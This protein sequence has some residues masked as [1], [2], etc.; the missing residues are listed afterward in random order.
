MSKL[1]Y[2]ACFTILLLTSGYSRAQDVFSSSELQDAIE[3]AVGCELSARVRMAL[4]VL[5][6]YQ[7]GVSGCES[8][9][10]SESGAYYRDAACSESV[11]FS[12]TGQQLFCSQITSSSTLGEGGSEFESSWTLSPGSTYD[13][14]A[15]SLDGME[16][17][18]RTSV[19]YRTIPTAAGECQL[20][21]RVYKSDLR[22]N[23]NQP[24]L[25]AIHGGSW[26]NRGF[27][28]FGIE[29][30]ATHYTSRGFVVF[31]P[32]YRLLGNSEGSAA[33]QGA[34]LP[35]IAEDVTAALNWVE[36]N[37]SDYGAAGKPVVFGQSAGAHLALT[38]AVAHAQQVAAAVLLYPPTDFTDLLTQLRSGEYSNEEGIGLMNVVLGDAQTYD[39]SLSPVPENS[40]PARVTGRFEPLPP[41]KILHGIADELVP[42]RQSIR[43]C[44]ALAD[45]DLSASVNAT[46]QLQTNIDC[47]FDSE[48]TL[49]LEGD[50]ALDICLTTDRVLSTLISEV[51][52]SGGEESRELVASELDRLANWAVEQTTDSTSV[53]DG[54]GAV[55]HLWFFLFLLLSGVIRHTKIN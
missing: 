45:R 22:R 2:P 23:S 32:F 49:F 26:R 53:T 3:T 43:L 19:V 34:K 30:A 38:L 9:V 24:G 21:M 11:N 29:V 5:P 54:T 7:I 42:A 27:G 47:G 16:Q 25:L 4:P 40:F 35:E 37:G 14:N 44:N 15:L 8:V 52:L 50:H 55:S 20:L 36:Q 33:C 12:T 39:L 48:L 41:M 31:A 13:I 51:C 10:P 28:S 17:P 18:Y 6:L 46:D 1:L